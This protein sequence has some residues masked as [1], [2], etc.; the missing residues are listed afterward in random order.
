MTSEF[1]EIQDVYWT[2][3]STRSNKT[4]LI[5]NG[6]VGIDGVTVHHPS[7]I[8]NDVSVS[9]G[10]EYRCCATNKAGDSCGLPSD[11]IGMLLFY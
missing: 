7:L 5:R 10:G 8:I 9:M 11:L 4:N 3:Y 6:E 1:L 2:V